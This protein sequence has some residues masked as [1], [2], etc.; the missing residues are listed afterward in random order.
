MPPESP[1]SLGDGAKIVI[2]TD[3]WHPQVNG[4]VRT[5]ST[6]TA[7]LQDMGHAVEL[8]TP[9]TFTTLP[10]PGYASIRLA[11][12]PGR[13]VARRLD[14][15]SPDAIHIATEGP[16]GQAA[17]RYCRQRGL[18]FTTAFHTQFPEYI[19]ARM[20]LP[21]DWS[22]AYL[23]RFHAHAE[24]TLVPTPSQRD[25]LAARGF[26][27]LRIWPRGVD[28]RVF[29]PGDKGFLAGERPLMINVGRVAVEKNLE[30]F[31]SLDLPGS[32]VVVGDGPDRA[33]LEKRF[34][35]ALFVGEKFGDELARHVAAADVMV[36][37]SLT[38]TFGLVMLEAMACGVPVA[39]FPVTGPVDVVQNGRTGVLDSDLAAAVRGALR[40]DPAD[41]VAYARAHSWRRC[42]QTFVANLAPIPRLVH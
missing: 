19:R 23:R 10:L 22:Y 28:T 30:A 34:P 37:P 27:H 13:E 20:P 8:I 38:D 36:F 2:V 4:V 39:A 16:L 7:E 32:K 9:E 31:L 40:L 3:A 17:H 11:V 15:F 12:M 1:P 14:A 24:R 35:Q 42:T 18:P 25:A 26:R 41:C 5:L 6:T 29:K 33:R 21:L